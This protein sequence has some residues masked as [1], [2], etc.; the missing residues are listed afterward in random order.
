MGSVLSECDI[1]SLVVV[2][3]FPSSQSLVTKISDLRDRAEVR[4]NFSLRLWTYR[5]KMAVAAA[6]SAL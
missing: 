5:P 3:S 2:L 1:S 4:G 6:W